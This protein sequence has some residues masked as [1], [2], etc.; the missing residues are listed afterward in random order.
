M[1]TNLFIEIVIYKSRKVFLCFHI[2][3]KLCVCESTHIQSKLKIGK[4]FVVA[5]ALWNRFYC[6]K[7]FQRNFQIIWVIVARSHTR[8]ELFGST[9]I[10]LRTKYQLAELKVTC[11]SATQR[12]KCKLLFNRI[13]E[14][15]EHERR[16]QR[17]P[18]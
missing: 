16:T 9:L 12:I 18:R 11:V 4:V 5:R 10:Q 8:V 13:C 17:H 14:V 15:L 3:H 2:V 7:I 6:R 1:Q